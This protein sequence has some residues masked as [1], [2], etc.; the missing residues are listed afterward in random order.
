MIINNLFII[1]DPG[2]IISMS[3]NWLSILLFILFTPKLF[4][5]KK[6]RFAWIFTKLASIVS[7]RTK[8]NINIKLFPSLIHF[9]VLFFIIF[10]YNFLSLYPF[11]FTPRA[12]IAVSIFFSFPFWLRIILKGW[13]TSFNKIITHLLPSNT[14]ILLC[15][16]IVMIETIRNIIRPLTL[17]IRLTANIIA[18]H[19]L[20]NL[21][22]NLLC[23]NIFLFISLSSILT[24]LL[25]LELAVSIIQSYV[26]IT[27]LSLYLNEI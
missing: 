23:S 16:F 6:N 12:H 13:F 18:G 5:R 20:I 3:L 15:S 22:R 14:P 25:T 19:I 10:L 1:F 24:I 21:L 8:N 4:F 11:N 7:Y 26:Y 9:K 2:T 27:L 17:S